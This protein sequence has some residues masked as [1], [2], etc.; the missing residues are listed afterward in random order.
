MRVARIASGSTASTDGRVAPL[1]DG[2]V[3]PCAL[4]DVDVGAGG[5]VAAIRRCGESIGRETEEGGAVEP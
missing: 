2:F 1:D 3:V 4:S 5:T